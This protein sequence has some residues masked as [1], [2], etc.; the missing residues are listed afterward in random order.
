MKRSGG[1]GPTLGG[2]AAI[3][4]LVLAAVA[5]GAAAA[6]FDGFGA[7]TG[8]IV[9]AGIAA[10]AG[11]AIVAR[12]PIA[13]LLAIVLLAASGFQPVLI[14]AGNVDVTI[15]DLFFAGLVF[16]WLQAMVQRIQTRPQE[17]PPIVPF[18]QAAAVAFLLFAGLT[19]FNVAA[20]EPASFGESSTSWLRLVQSATLAWLAASVLETPRQVRLVLGAIVAGAV[21]AVIASIAIGGGSLDERSRGTLGPNILGLMCGFGMVIAAIGTV[22]ARTSLRL[23]AIALCLVGLLLAQ[24]VASFVAV[25]F[26][27]ALGAAL[28]AAPADSPRV[29]AAQ[30]A[31]RVALAVALAGLVVFGV[32]QQLRPEVTPGGEGFRAGSGTH[33]A[34]LATAG[35][36][37][38]ERNPIVG[39]GW[40]GSNDPEIIGS[41]EIASEVRRRFPQ[42]RAVFFPDVSPT[43][44]H[45]LY[46]QLLA[47]L[48]LVGFFLFLGLAA[49]I[50]WRAV[51]LLRR[52]GRGHELWRPAFAMSLCLL[53]L[54]IWHNDNPLYG[55]QTETVIPVI[56]IGTLAAVA[57]MTLPQ[58]GGRS[59]QEAGR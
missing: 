42:S 32:V 19:L 35:L 18:G 24:S 7:E 36:E 46:V 48:G 29:G 53:L 27:L 9:L 38:F 55:G 20:S 45:N 56:L 26:A 25:G 47:D 52:L 57:K 33:R 28:Y 11:L 40:R 39:V 21:I 17:R 37:I 54:L 51:E 2:L 1:L 30:R 34:I 23:G 5:G 58:P 8:T 43:S 15:T 41:R 44:V 14:N 10:L 59:A 13:C 50:G 12:G 6:R 16:W 31:T 4:G 22:P 3:A 49:V